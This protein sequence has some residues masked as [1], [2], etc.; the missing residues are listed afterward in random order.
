MCTGSGCIGLS[1]LK[2]L[3]EEKNIEEGLLPKIILADISKEALLISEKNARSLFSEKSSLVKSKI[4]FCQTNLFENL[5]ETFDIIVSNP[6]YIPSHITEELLKDGR[7]EP[8]LAL[9]GDVNLNGEKSQSNDGLEVIRN[10]IPQAKKR[11]SP[12]GII[13]MET[14]EYNAKKAAKIAENLGFKS[15][16]HK[17]LEGQ[18]RVVELR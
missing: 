2:N 8:R 14:G 4:S 12:G 3:L 16:I 1:I 9:D 15:K 5:K 10:L 11:L 17:D 7:S 6:P 18:L 13:L